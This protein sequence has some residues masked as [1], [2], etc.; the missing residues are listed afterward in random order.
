MCNKAQSVID[1]AYCATLGINVKFVEEIG[2]FH[3][4]QQNRNEVM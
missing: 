2:L 3:T 1:Y 4:K